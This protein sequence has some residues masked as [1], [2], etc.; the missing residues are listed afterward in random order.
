MRHCSRGRCNAHGHKNDL[1]VQLV[2][3]LLREQPLEITLGL[4]HAHAIAQPR[5]LGQAMNVGV[6]WEGGHAEGL[7]YHHRPVIPAGCSGSF[8]LTLSA[9]NNRPLLTC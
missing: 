6:H 3:G 5:A 1:Q 4:L 7:R 9:R 8:V 2:P